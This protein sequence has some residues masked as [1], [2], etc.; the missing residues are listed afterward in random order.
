MWSKGRW[1]E[2]DKIVVTSVGKWGKV[3][4]RKYRRVIISLRVSDEKV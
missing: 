1:S 4:W 3:V 2:G